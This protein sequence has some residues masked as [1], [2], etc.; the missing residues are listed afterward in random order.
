MKRIMA[1]MLALV[2]VTTCMVST[3]PFQVLCKR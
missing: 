2:M 3:R 1:F